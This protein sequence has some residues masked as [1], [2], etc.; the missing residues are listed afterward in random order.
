MSATILPFAH[1]RRRP[2][3]VC[4]QIFKAAGSH[5]VVCLECRMKNRLDWD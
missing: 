2:C 3:M 4:K 5:N 1:T